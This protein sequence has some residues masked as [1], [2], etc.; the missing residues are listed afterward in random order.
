LPA[1]HG[2]EASGK[3]CHL[4]FPAIREDTLYSDR[5]ILKDAGSGDIVDIYAPC[6]YDPL[7]K[8]E[9]ARQQAHRRHLR[10]CQS[11]WRLSDR[12]SRR[13]ARRNAISSELIDGKPHG[14]CRTD[15]SFVVACERNA[16]SLFVEK[17]DGRQVQRVE[18]PNWLR[19]SLQ[20]SYKYSRSEFNQGDAAQ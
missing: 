5:P 13:A 8:D 2:A 20:R 3:F 17:I 1:W 7:G 19:K 12:K 15:Q 11:V 18:R 4:R 14:A 6:D 9:V 10:N 16:L